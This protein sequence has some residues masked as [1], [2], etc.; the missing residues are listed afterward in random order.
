MKPLETWY[1]SQTTQQQL[2]F[3]KLQFYIIQQLDAFI[4]SFNQRKCLNY[5]KR[6]KLLGIYLYGGVGSGKT[7]LIDQLFKYTHSP[8]KHRLHFHIFMQQIHMSLSEYKHTANPMALVA[9][10]LAKKYTVIFLDE[11]YIVDIATAMIMQNLLKEL[12]KNRIAIITSSNFKPD[13]LYKNELMWERFTPA[14][15][16]LNQYLL[17]LNLTTNDYRLQDASDLTLDSS[18]LLEIDYEL[19]N[20]YLNILGRKIKYIK[21]LDK[22]IWFDFSSL[23]GDGRSQLDYIELVKYYNNFTLLNI[24]QELSDISQRT[25]FI[26]LVDILYDSNMQLNISQ[27]IDIK[28]LYNNDSNG[29]NQF[30]RTQSRLYEMQTNKYKQRILNNVK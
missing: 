14:I 6:P 8:K 12:F 10:N 13:D 1:L 4:T 29:F 30:S 19:N 7:M 28:K 3:D 20:N 2:I 17:V 15:E 25:R 27:T 26:W 5:F 18:K 22:H 24:P 21:Q 23:C 11:M 16:L 9:K